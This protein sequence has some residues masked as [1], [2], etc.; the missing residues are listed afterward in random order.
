MTRAVA[1]PLKVSVVAMLPTVRLKV[2]VMV[3]PQLSVA[4]TVT[5][6]GVIEAGPALLTVITPVL[7]LPAKLPV[8]PG[9]A[10]ETE[11]TLPLSVGAVPGVTVME[12]AAVTVLVG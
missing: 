3:D 5:R 10:A 7:G 11:T 9:A 4:V 12:P 8:K 1:G 2:L 6:Y